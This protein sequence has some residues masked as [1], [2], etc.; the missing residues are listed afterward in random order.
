VQAHLGATRSPFVNAILSLNWSMV[1]DHVPWRTL[2]VMAALAVLRPWDLP[3]RLREQRGL[4][5]AIAAGA[6]L[7][8]LGP[9]LPL[10]FGLGTIPGPYRALVELPGFTALRVPARMLHVALL[11]T[12]VLAAGAVVVLR[13]VVWRAPLAATLAAVVA[14][15]AELPPH[16]GGLLP[17]PP[18]ERIDR[19]HAWL[20]TQPRTGGVVFL[21]HD[22]FGLATATV[23]FA[24][25][26]HWQP[27]LQGMS[28]VL[29]PMYPWMS[30]RLARFPAPD[31]VTDLRALGVTR[32]VVRTDLVPEA[33]R[34]ALADA[35]RAR[36][37]LKRRW[38]A[39]S[40]VVFSLRP[41]S[42][43]SAPR[44]AG[45]PVP[46]D[47]WR[48]TASVAP[49]LAPRAIDDD[50]ATAWQSWGDLDAS[51]QRAWYHPMSVLDRWQVFLATTPA[52]LTVDLGATVPAS[53]IHVLFGG[54]DPMV[55][56][57]ARLDVS[58]DEVTWTPLPLAPFPD[59]RALV[60]RAADAPLAAVPATPRPVRYVRIAVAAYDGHVRDVAVFT[61]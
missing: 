6:L 33:M 7:F 54:S 23:Q 13:Q 19:A 45:R 20:A 44:D 11:G 8:A 40:T 25:T 36:R 17:V 32:A 28:G 48:A 50:V 31:V 24:S 57:E 53:A 16:T 55:L 58:V 3:R 27:M 34:T 49:S 30:G 4:F 29:P 1:A 52:T 56:P 5:L 46:R 60:T 43:R 21:P 9:A 37:L 51:V 39:G 59:V 38:A 61:R 15:A 35:E 10:P 14:L 2:L 42:R 22:P 26:R 12:S 18:P 41:A 47:G